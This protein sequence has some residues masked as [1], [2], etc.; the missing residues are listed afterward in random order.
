M[1]W[2]RKVILAVSLAGLLFSGSGLAVTFVDDRLFEDMTR[3]LVTWQVE[4]KVRDL[5]TLPPAEEGGALAAMRNKLADSVELSERLLGTDLPE[6]IAER[7]AALCVCQL[8]IEDREE[9]QRRFEAAKDRIAT[10]I[11]AGLAGG[12]A[13]TGIQIET[14][15]DLIAGYYTETVDGLKRD[16]R[17]FFGSNLALYA[18]VG[19]GVVLSSVGVAL[20]A[21]AS[22]LL[23]G[24]FA[25]SG[26][27][28]F[29]QNWLAT[30]LF[31]SW[32]GYW[33]LAWVAFIT[34]FLVDVF[35]N[36]ARVTLRILSSIQWIP[37]PTLPC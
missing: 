29:G 13:L 15:D 28:L 16:L 21:P 24:T 9:Q 14:L 18:I 19:L 17:V 11:R 35:L 36:R 12:A 30:I 22:L 5:A 32:T 7:T 31:N 27:Y 1:D 8:G 10:K 4:R 25:S 6:R 37:V 23:L 33:Y 3:K 2:L 26:L 34:A 20:V